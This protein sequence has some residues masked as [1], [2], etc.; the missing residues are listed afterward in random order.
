MVSSLQTSVIVPILLDS[1][2]QCT[3]QLQKATTSTNLSLLSSL[4]QEGNLEMDGRMLFLVNPISRRSY[5]TKLPG[6]AYSI[7][8]ASSLIALL[9]Q[10]D[11]MFMTLETAEYWGYPIWVYA[12]P[13]DKQARTAR[14]IRIALV[15][16]A[17]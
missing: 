3:T 5:S 9:S 6:S 15:Q 4:W 8:R 14:R 12:G 10:T 13:M 11:Y 1:W 7:H 16:Y 2:A 17:K